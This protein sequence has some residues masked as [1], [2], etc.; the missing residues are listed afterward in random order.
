MLRRIRITT[1]AAVALTL[2]G[3]A[4]A[5]AECETLA[6]CTIER[7]QQTVA[8]AEQAVRDAPG[9]VEATVAATRAQVEAAVVGVDRSLTHDVYSCVLEGRRTTSTTGFGFAGP[10][11]CHHLDRNGA[12]DG[13]DDSGVRTGRFTFS[14]VTQ[15]D[16]CP[17]WYIRGSLNIALAGDREPVADEIQLDLVDGRGVLTGGRAA[18]V[19]SLSLGVVALTR[20][21]VLDGDA[22]A[23]WPRID[24]FCSFE[25]DSFIEA[26]YTLARQTPRT[27]RDIEDTVYD[28]LP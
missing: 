16:T 7:A 3:S 18:Q 6:A 9:T 21:A 24:G 12:S 26:T 15:Y 10:A 13:G 14:M 8:Q 20:T 27:M 23:V 11:T 17:T 2:A 22:N 5:L 1:G 25:D 19:P 28:A 4:P